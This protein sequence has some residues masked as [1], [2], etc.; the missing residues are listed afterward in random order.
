MVHGDHEQLG[1]VLVIVVVFDAIPGQEEENAEFLLKHNMAVR[2]SDGNS[3]RAA[4]V[5]L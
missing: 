2:I 4:I 5:E 1:E 3:C